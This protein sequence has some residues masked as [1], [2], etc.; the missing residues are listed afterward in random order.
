[1]IDGKGFFGLFCASQPEIGRLVELPALSSQ[2]ERQQRNLVRACVARVVHAVTLR[3]PPS[4]TFYAL[5]L[6]ARQRAGAASVTM[7]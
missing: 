7:G 1:M 2:G 5:N 4:G 6:L 3:L